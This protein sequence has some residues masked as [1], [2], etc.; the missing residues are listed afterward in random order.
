MLSLESKFYT[1][2]KY[3]E[4]DRTSVL[5]HHWHYLCHASQLRDQG[6]FLASDLLSHPVVAI[7]KGDEI[8]VY[9]NV[10]QHRGG[11]VAEGEGRKRFLSCKCHSSSYNLKGELVGAPDFSDD[12][13]DLDKSCIKLKKIAH[14]IWQGMVFVYLGEGDKVYDHPGTE[15]LERI[16][17]T[18]FED[19]SFAK[20]VVYDVN[21]NWKTYIDNYLEGYH[22]PYV[23]PELNDL[24]PQGQYELECF[25]NWS[26]QHSPIKNNAGQYGLKE[27]HAWYAFIYPNAMLN[28]LPGRLQINRVLPKTALSCEVIF[29]FV[30]DLSLVDDLEKVLKADI[31]YSDLVQKQDIKIC[32]DAQKGLSSPAYNQGFLSPKHEKALRHFQ[33]W[34]RKKYD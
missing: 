1:E 4:I 9:Y 28:L 16:K 20:R 21:A 31:E 5:S 15:I 24:L 8:A 18:T 12:E 25:D 19:W 26:L 11:P 17:P 6:S 32:E 13:N 22:I 2:T 29:D 3:D 27:G 14:Q 10:C 30:Y 7:N 33:Q 34:L 23:H